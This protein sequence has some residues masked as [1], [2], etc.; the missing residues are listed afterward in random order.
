[1][2]SK[3]LEDGDVVLRPIEKNDVDFL[4]KLFQHP[5][6]R[7]T[8]GRPP[9]P[10]NL[11]QQE[12][13]IEKTRENDGKESFIIEYDGKKAGEVSIGGLEKPY[14]KSEFGISIHPDFHG[15]GIDS[16]ATKLIVKYAFETLNRHKLRGGYIEG[17]K[18]SRRI[19]EK[20][21]LQEEGRE[22]HYKY[23]DEEWKDVIWMSIL[24]SEYFDE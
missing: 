8:I 2:R 11:N 7:N 5:N 10:S 12:D 15:Q 22:R 9:L 21:G 19:Q 4:Q 14:R 6:V 17:N 13:F 24:E 20:A 23:V 18:A 1:M 3:F 16:A